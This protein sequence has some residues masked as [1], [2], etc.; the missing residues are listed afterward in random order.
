MNTSLRILL[1]TFLFFSMVGCVSV[2]ISDT[3]IER[4]RAVH[5][6]APTSPYAEVAHGNLDRLWKN[7]SNGNTI[8]YLSEC[9]ETNDPDLVAVQTGILRGVSQLNILKS[10]TITYN[11]REALH[12][13]ATGKVDGVAT[14]MELMIFKKNGCLYTLNYV[15]LASHFNKDQKIFN[16]FIGQYRAP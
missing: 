5:F 12:T 7:S 4:A 10:D 13:V 16:D 6:R 11:D 3:K 1:R 9:S 14:T 2:G 15:G 8:S